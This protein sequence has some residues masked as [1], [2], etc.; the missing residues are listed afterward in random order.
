MDEKILEIL[1]LVLELNNI[2]K[3]CSQ[4]NCEKWDSLKH[5]ELMVEIESEFNVELE[6]EEIS[7]MKSFE[8]IK[9]ILQQ[10]R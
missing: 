8:D 4:A 7:K 6:P 3:S 5:L 2:D 9:K 10:Y 1:K